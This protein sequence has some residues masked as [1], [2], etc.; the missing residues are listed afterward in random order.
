MKKYQTIVYKCGRNSFFVAK[1]FL[2]KMWKNIKT[3]F[4]SVVVRIGFAT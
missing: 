4:K 1:R 2:Q 3:I